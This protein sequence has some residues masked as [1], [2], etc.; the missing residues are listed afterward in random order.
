MLGS[1][2]YFNKVTSDLIFQTE[3]P[4]PSA[5][6]AFTF[7]NLD[8][9]VINN[10][11][12]LTLDA[13]VVDNADFSWQTIFTGA[14]LN[15]EVRDLQGIVNTGAINGQ[16]LTGAY[17]QRIANGQPLFAY[18]LRE[19]EGYDSEGLGIYGNNGQLSFVGDPLP[20]VNIG[21]ANNF[22]F[23]NFDA[24]IFFQGVF[25]YQIYNNTANAIFLRGNLRNGRNTTIDNANSVENPDNFG[26][27]S[28]R[29]LEDGDFVRL[30]NASIGY[31]LPASASSVLNN[32][33]FYVTG[34]NLLTFTGYSGY[35]PEVNTQKPINGVPS[36]G[37]DYTS[38]PRPRTILIGLNAN[39]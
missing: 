2:D 14:Y 29:F 9:E 38:Y 32:V 20:D 28:T 10:G 24:S 23:G 36:L 11:V 33:R 18:Y 4:L 34:Q 3:Q 25:G 19:F 8:A 22:S 27:A 6:S 17:A 30:Q 39:F 13:R 26:E 1:L 21:L 37:I 15:N 16:G 31:T 12:E 35:D 5:G 7:E